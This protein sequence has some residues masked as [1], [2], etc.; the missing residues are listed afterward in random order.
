M[1]SHLSLLLIAVACCSVFAAEPVYQT[2]FETD[3]VQE[4]WL[5]G[6]GNAAQDWREGDAAAGRHSL[7]ISRGGWLS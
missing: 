4:G 3:P 6:K 2:D 1:E 5:S 7:D